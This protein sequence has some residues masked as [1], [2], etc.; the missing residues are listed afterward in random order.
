MNALVRRRGS[1]GRWADEGALLAPSP[2]E[3]GRCRRRPRP[4][5]PAPPAPAP[6]SSG[7][8]RGS[9]Q[10]VPGAAGTRSSRG[11]SVGGR[12]EAPN[13]LFPSGGAAAPAARAAQRAPTVGTNFNR[14]PVGSPR[15][16]GPKGGGSPPRRRGASPGHHLGIAAAPPGHHLGIAPP[17]PGHHLGIAPPPPGHH[18][19][20]A[21][22][23]PR[24]QHSPAVP[25][26]PLSPGSGRARPK[27]RRPRLGSPAPPPRV[28]LRSAPLR[29]DPRRSVPFRSAPPRGPAAPR[30]RRWRLTQPRGPGLCPSG[31]VGAPRGPRAASDRGPSPP[32][33][34]PAVCEGSPGSGGG[35][36]CCAAPERGTRMGFAPLLRGGPRTGPH[37]AS[38]GLVTRAEEHRSGRLRCHRPSR[39]FG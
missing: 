38:L 25:A 31:R 9:G 24:G 21:P 29:S 19:G 12:W 1:R 13:A 2:T 10:L 17:P 18:L 30:A 11:R 5:P 33:R 26:V 28:P 20:I 34:A 3:P 14:G 36:R 16:G 8:S 4:P 27:Y 23:S 35:R 15:P 6:A 7:G 39:Y 32:G 22:A 37:Y